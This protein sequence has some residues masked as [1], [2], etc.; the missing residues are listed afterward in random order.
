MP[1]LI[2]LVVGFVNGNCGNALAFCRTASC[3]VKTQTE[4]A[5]ILIFRLNF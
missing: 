5:N 2:M 3:R 4:L 1:D